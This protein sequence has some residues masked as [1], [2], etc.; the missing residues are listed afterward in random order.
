MS[1][2]SKVSKI[3]CKQ[4]KFFLF[5]ISQSIWFSYTPLT[6]AHF[7]RPNPFSIFFDF[8]VNASQRGSPKRNAKTVTSHQTGDRTATKKKLR[9]GVESMVEVDLFVTKRYRCTKTRLDNR[10]HPYDKRDRRESNRDRKS[11]NR[12]EDRSKDTRT[13]DRRDS[14]R[15]DY[16]RR[17]M[18]ASRSLSYNGRSL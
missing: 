11:Y 10:S 8:K 13:Y 16:E 9:L 7:Q 18:L 15:N 17:Y 5:F 6:V 1:H 12:N 4:Q 2:K 3:T 14:R